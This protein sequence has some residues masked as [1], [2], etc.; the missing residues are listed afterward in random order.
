MCI[1]KCR[2]Y[3]NYR[4][5]TFS[6]VEPKPAYAP[7]DWQPSVID[8]DTMNFNQAPYVIDERAYRILIRD[9]VNQLSLRESEQPVF[10]PQNEFAI[11]FEHLAELLTMV[12]K[13]CAKDSSRPVVT[14]KYDQVFLRLIPV[15]PQ[16]DEVLSFGMPR[17]MM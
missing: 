15:R 9:I 5:N 3:L 16:L 11:D 10:L 12:H 17:N 6:M 2:Y 14:P 7:E 4:R 13:G 1:Q 8:V